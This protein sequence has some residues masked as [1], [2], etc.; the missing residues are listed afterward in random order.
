MTA[1]HGATPPKRRP[2]KRDKAVTNRIA[3]F[4]GVMLI[5]FFVVDGILFSGNMSVF[6][7]R[8]FGVLTEYIIFWR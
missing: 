5:G 3:I 6:L 7:G 4:L 2:A 1:T 8:K